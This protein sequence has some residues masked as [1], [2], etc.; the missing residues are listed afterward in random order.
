[1]STEGVRQLEERRQTLQRDAHSLSETGISL[2]AFERLG[3]AVREFDTTVVRVLALERTLFPDLA[4][5]L[6]LLQNCVVNLTAE[7]EMTQRRVQARDF[8]RNAARLVAE[9]LSLPIVA[10]VPI[11]APPQPP[12]TGV[13]VVQQ[14]W[15]RLVNSRPNSAFAERILDRLEAQGVD[16]GEAREKLEEYQAITRGDYESGAEG[17]DEY[18]EAREEAW[19]DFLDTLESTQ[20]P[21]EQ[22]EEG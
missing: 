8:C 16:L 13:G 22:E 3:R 7:R 21:E 4:E 6:E 1:M 15:D 2:N 5:A 12:P 17:S 14:A 9:A 10:L 11:L 18:R 20:E 19:T